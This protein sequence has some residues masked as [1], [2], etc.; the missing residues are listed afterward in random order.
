MLGLRTHSYYLTRIMPAQGNDVLIV[1]T[2][3]SH[4]RPSRFHPLLFIITVEDLMNLRNML[5]AFWVSSALFSTTLQA[6]ESRD[7]VQTVYVPAITVTASPEI[8][9]TASVSYT[10]I[11]QAQIKELYN[12][13][14]MPVLLSHLPS[15]TTYSDAGNGIGYTYLTMR[16]FDQR[17]IAVT[18]NGIPQ[19]DPEDHNVYW[20]DFPDLA[21]STGRIQVQRGAGLNTY[22]P[23]AIGGSVNISSTNIA[24][25][26]SVTL[27][28]GMGW[29]SY[30]AGDGKTVPNV[31][32]FA[33][34]FQSG[35]IDT[36]YA[37]AAR[38]SRINS[39]GYRELSDATL[40]SYFLS[41][42]VLSD[43][44]TTQINMFGGPLED[45]L[46]YYGVAKN[47]I[48]DPVMR[49]K[50]Y[51]Y[52]ETDGE[53]NVAYGAPRRSQEVEN[54]SQPHYELL[55][56]W[57]VS[58]SV[59]VKSSLFY[60]KGTGFFDFDGS[61]ADAATLQLTPENGFEEGVEPTDAI[62]RSFVD[63]DHYGWIPRVELDHDGGI[64]TIGAEIRQHRSEHYGQISYAGGLPSGYDPDYK[65]Y[66]YDG[67]RD[68]YSLWFREVFN[69]SRE[70]TL[71]ADL[72]VTY[73]RY[74]MTN[75]FL[76]NNP[77]EYASQNG[78][79]SGAG[80]I[81]SVDYVFVNPRVGANY[82][83]DDNLNVWTSVALTTREPRMANLFDASSIAYGETPL[84]QSEVVDGEQVYDFENP[85]VNPEQ[86]LDIELG[87]YYRSEDISA[88]ITAYYMSFTDE[89][90]KSGQ[91]GIFGDPIDGNAP[92]T[93]HMGLEL[94]AS[95]QVLGTPESGILVSANATFSTNEITEF[96]FVTGVDSLGQEVSVDLAGNSIAG[97]PDVLANVM[98]TATHDNASLTILNKYVGEFY[99]DNFQNEINKNDAWNVVNVYASYLF[100]NTPIVK[101]VRVNMQMNNAL[102]SLYSMSGEGD[103]FFPGAERNYYF[104]VALGL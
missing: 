32:K 7:S 12:Y 42:V 14:D 62:I 45:E 57:A 60:Y 74:G 53:G 41:A 77:V 50:N 52:L 27:S 36:S 59:T 37:V 2:L 4:T 81:F 11:D 85:L 65:F 20:I 18:I 70:L 82:K 68:I 28:T 35:L 69:A 56:D 44:F 30:Q 3:L 73:N 61:W 92:K 6:A 51:S 72:Q 98:V 10:E 29:Q 21:A 86:L 40:N 91:L 97:F 5:C 66:Q 87:A 63:N 31:S 16:G 78:I 103:Q 79:V 96:A 8:T 47:D 90:V 95:A 83:V 88:D 94:S 75:V 13:E 84:F 15:I 9:E 46:V 24:A 49:L 1:V 23:A 71:S 26:R 102:N 76:G 67:E 33:F 80:E 104:G 43:D 17:R 101:D 19:N 99:T 34:D 48:D 39:R 55:N 58:E 93:M 64:L 100:T 54:F 22:G 25:E 89:L 38:I